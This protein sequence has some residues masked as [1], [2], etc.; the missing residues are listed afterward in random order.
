MI[1]RQAFENHLRD[2][3]LGISTQYYVSNTNN[4][5]SF[6][7]SCKALQEHPLPRQILK[8]NIAGY[9]IENNWNIVALQTRKGDV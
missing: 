3:S 6:H 8:S 4:E 5:L 7:I 2:V 9:Q 1:G